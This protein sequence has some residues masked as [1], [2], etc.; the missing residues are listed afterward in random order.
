MKIY[1]FVKVI[2]LLQHLPFAV[3]D[4]LPLPPLAEASVE[5]RLPRLL[6]HGICHL[7]GYDHETDVE[8]EEM[9][10]REDQLLAELVSCPAVTN[11]ST[12]GCRAETAASL[13]ALSEHVEARGERQLSLG[14]RKRFSRRRRLSKTLIL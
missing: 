10:A 12:R 2:F 4:P 1:T 9:L 3:I 14:N 6:S 7:M 5:L 8:F 11:S 13:S